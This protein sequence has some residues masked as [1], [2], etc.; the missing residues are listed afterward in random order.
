MIK[1]WRLIDSAVRSMRAL[2]LST[3]VGPGLQG[4]M[5]GTLA[6]QEEMPNHLINAAEHQ[7]LSATYLIS[8]FR[9]N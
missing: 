8:K 4:R 9:V 6:S 5:N 1:D 2:W 7:L 3:L